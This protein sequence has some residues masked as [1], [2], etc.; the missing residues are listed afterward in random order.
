MLEFQVKYGLFS[1][2]NETIFLK[3]EQSA[4][5]T[6]ELH[7]SSIVKHTQMGGNDDQASLRE[8]TFFLAVLASRGHQANNQTPQGSWAV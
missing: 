8:C 1:T 3:Q 5:G 7:Y 6:W 4:N 2:Y